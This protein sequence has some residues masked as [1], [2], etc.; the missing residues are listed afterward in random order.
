MAFISLHLL[1]LLCFSEFDAPWF[2]G[3]AA[4][5]PCLFPQARLACYVTDPGPFLAVVRQELL[6]ALV[7]ALTG[8]AGTGTVLTAAPGGTGQ[9]AEYGCH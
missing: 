4:V 8:G 1:L 5:F 6:D 9:A 7:S 3:S 2:H